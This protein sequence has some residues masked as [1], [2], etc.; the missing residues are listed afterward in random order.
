MNAV[1]VGNLRKRLAVENNRIRKVLF[2]AK[3]LDF[4]PKGLLA[5]PRKTGAK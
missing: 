2:D 3:I 1:F 4:G 5:Y